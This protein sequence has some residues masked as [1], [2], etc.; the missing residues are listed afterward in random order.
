M[1]PLKLA[2]GAAALAV[3]AATLAASPVRIMAVG[4]SLTE[5]DPGY[6]G[7]LATALREAGHSVEFVGSRSGTTRHEGFGGFTIGPG[8]SKA[9]EWTNGKGN[10]HA[11]LDRM[12]ANEKPDVLLLLIGV[13][14]Y[15]NIKN[16]PDYK[17]DRDGPARLAGVLDK[18]HALSPST[19]VVFS[20]VLPVKWDAQFARGFNRALPAL[21]AERPFATFAD[22]NT[23]VGFTEGDWTD[24]LHLS[25][26][27]NA[28]LAAAWFSALEP[29][30]ATL[31]SS[32]SASPAAPAR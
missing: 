16:D 2:L 23:S 26:S 3:G 32:P 31:R 29:V 14:D 1:S 9:D 24:G 13:N 19:R 17:V 22:L 18:I 10:I 5:N 11:Q 12:L 20:S 4:D 15:F 21:A 30:L 7:P 25:A 8:P 6:R 28:K 27:G